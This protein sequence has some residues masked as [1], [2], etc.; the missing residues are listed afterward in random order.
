MRRF[1]LA[2][3]AAALLAVASFG[4]VAAEGNGPSHCKDEPAIGQRFVSPAGDPPMGAGQSN[5]NAGGAAR[6]CNPLGTP[7]IG[8]A[9]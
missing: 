5:N 6:Y 4:S 7:P 3:G 8:P 2:F 1:T 9:L